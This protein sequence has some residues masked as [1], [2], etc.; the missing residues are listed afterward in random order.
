[1]RSQRILFLATALIEVGAGLALV[2][3]PAL[4]IGLL[5]GVREP[6][7]EALAVG[8]LGGAGL[9]AIGLACWLARDDRGS[10]SQHGLLWAMLVYNVG[11][12]GVLGFAGSMLS[13]AGV[14]LWPG[15][16]LHAF[17]TI[18]CALD[19]RASGQIDAAAAAR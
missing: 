15:V 11:A 13:M 4:V 5:L 14:A 10:R 6:S 19:L 1:M 16:G 2:V 18:W 8:R 7:P 17:M 12:C 3:L 9:L